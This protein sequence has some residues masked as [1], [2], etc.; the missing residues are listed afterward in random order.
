[1]NHVLLPLA[2]STNFSQRFKAH[3]LVNN[4]CSIMLSWQAQR[5]GGGRGFLHRKKSPNIEFRSHLKTLC[6]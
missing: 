6:G 5:G 1:V 3:G 2:L 4:S